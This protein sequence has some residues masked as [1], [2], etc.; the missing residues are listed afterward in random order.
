LPA[1]QSTVVTATS[2][3]HIHLIDVNHIDAVERR[4]RRKAA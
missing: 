4:G 2:D 3:G 1:D